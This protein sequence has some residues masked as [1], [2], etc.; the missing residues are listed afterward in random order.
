MKKFFIFFFIS[1]LLIGIFIPVFDYYLNVERPAQS[2]R[3]SQESRN[4]NIKE[5]NK[6]AKEAFYDG[7]YKGAVSYY[8][9]IIKNNPFAIK[10]R[11]NLAFI[12]NELGRLEDENKILL[13]TAI[14]SDDQNDYLNLAVNFYELNNNLASNFILEKKLNKNLED[15][16]FLYK[17]YYYLIKNNLDLNQLDQAEKYLMKITNLKMNKSDIYLLSAELNKRKGNFELAYKDYYNSY[18][19]SRSQSFLYKNM[20]EMLEKAGREIDAYNHWQRTLDYGWFKELAY[21]KIN[22]Y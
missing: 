14:L 12:Y 2:V 7:N 13:Q 16:N 6:L 10:S 17:K 9:K 15:N 18:K 4:R 5:L 8:Q 11:R 20:A 21:K 3:I 1:A 22:H 19:A